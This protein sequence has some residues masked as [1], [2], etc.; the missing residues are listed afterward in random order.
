[1]KNAILIAALMAVSAVPCAFAQQ[2]PASPPAQSAQPQ[3]PTPSETDAQIAKMQELM[4]Q[5]NQ[6]MSQ[7]QQA[8]DPAERQKLMQQHWA[9]MQAAM[10]LM[11]G[12][13]GG[14]MGG[15]MMGPMMS[16]GDY[17]KM[18]SEQRAQRQYMMEHWMPM[19][20]MMMG[21][22]MQHQGMM[23]QPGTMMPQPAPKPAQ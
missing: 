10:T 19:Q 16:W 9:T 1:M 7:M 2:Q 4:T 5:M 12:A 18:T 14:G 22:M 3:Q 23:M 21:H 8:K 11:E 13:W 20:Q 17:S 6:Q 15:H